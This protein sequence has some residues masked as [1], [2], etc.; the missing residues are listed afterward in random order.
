MFHM[1]V[2]AVMRRTKRFCFSE[3]NIPDHHGKLNPGKEE[4]NAQNRTRKNLNEQTH[5][6]AQE[7]PGQENDH[8]QYHE[9]STRPGTKPDVASH[10]S[11]SMAQRDSA[12][13]STHQIHHSVVDRDRLRGHLAIR[14]V[15]VI[16]SYGSDD[17]VAKG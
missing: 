4:N 6:I 13:S 1:A 2:P 15:R 9:S 5:R 14:K 7:K 12:N 10:S 11:R 3:S 8:T 17:S 16:L